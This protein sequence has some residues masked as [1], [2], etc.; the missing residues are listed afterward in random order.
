M[1]DITISFSKILGASL[2]MGLIAKLTFDGINGHTSQNLALIVGIGVG[3]VVYGVM[4]YF[5]K[6]EE[7]DVLL[8]T[9]KSKFKK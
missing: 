4:I 7:V 1:K 3:V 9:L 6:I 8:G 5:M 2:V